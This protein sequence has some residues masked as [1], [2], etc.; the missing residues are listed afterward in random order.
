VVRLQF[1]DTYLAG[2]ALAVPELVDG[3]EEL[4][5]GLDRELAARALLGEERGKVLGAVGEAVFHVEGARAELDLAVGAHEALRVEG[6]LQCVRALAHDRR[7][8]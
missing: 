3:L 7:L 2:K 8:A 5:A 4:V 6:L 1:K